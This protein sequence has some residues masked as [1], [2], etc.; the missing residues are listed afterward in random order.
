MPIANN[1]RVPVQVLRSESKDPRGTN[2]GS[3]GRVNK[4]PSCKS[5]SF[6]ISSNDHYDAFEMTNRLLAILQE[7]ILKL[8]ELQNWFIEDSFDK[9]RKNRIIFFLIF[10]IGT[11]LG[12]SGLLGVQASKLQK[13]LNQTIVEV[14]HDMPKP[15]R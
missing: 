15:L 7:K 5:S 4:G 13:E 12:T 3:N 9:R 11:I 6:R 2:I 1:N 10:M 14:S 8:V